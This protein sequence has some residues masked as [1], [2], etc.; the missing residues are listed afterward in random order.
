M[1]TDLAFI[2]FI[3]LLLDFVLLW[4]AD[5]R[6]QSNFPTT[7]LLLQTML[8]VYIL[9]RHGNPSR[10]LL[11]ITVICNLILFLGALL[12]DPSPAFVLKFSAVVFFVTV[13]TWI[14]MYFN[15]LLIELPSESLFDIPLFWV[16][17]GAM[18]FYAGHLFNCI[19]LTAFVTEARAFSYDSWIL[20][21]V[22]NILKNICLAAGLAK[23]YSRR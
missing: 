17:G 8:F 6:G 9:H 4:I 14:V 11:L 19:F 22:L 23:C 3:S 12:F 16:S 5:V 15:R 10:R 18:L 20:H 21:D 1:G 7:I 2:A 13:M